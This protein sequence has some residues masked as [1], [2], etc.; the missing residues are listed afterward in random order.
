MS[1]AA[2][3]RSRINAILLLVAGAMA[4]GF[5]LYWH[6]EGRIESLRSRVA[7]QKAYAAELL[8][9]GLVSEAAAV[10]EQAAGFAPASAESLRLRRALADLRMNRLG[11]YEKAL[12]DLVFIKTTDPAQANALEPD[13]R[14]CLDR[15][16]RVYDVQRRLLLEGGANPTVV[17]A[18]QTTAVRFGNEAGITAAELEQRLVLEKIPL[19]GAPREALDRAVQGLLGEK[20]LL[21]AA[22]R[23]Q[24][25][26]RPDFIEQV[27]R[28]EDNLALLRYLEERVMK[29]VDVDEQTIG[30]YLEK[31]RDR[32]QSP[33]RVVYSVLDFPDETSAREYAAGRPASAPRTIGDHL[34]GTRQELPAALQGIRWEADPPKGPLGPVELNGRWV[35]Y[36]IH[37]I[38]A[39]TSVA[40]ELA[41]QQARLELLERRKGDRLSQA[42]AEL[43]R[44]EDVRVIDETIT[45]IFLPAS[46]TA[47]L[48]PNPGK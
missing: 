43:A 33:L 18:T 22:K 19:R 36:M 26:R 12:A 11:D 16:G 39:G 29:D 21:R 32:F 3:L 35:I 37:D 45:R 41:R 34:S 8:A 25:D 47:E 9:H 27:K 31:N 42:I 46:P 2:G 4:V 14:Q 38:V 1:G 40:P 20:L 10:M 6:G 15:L 48:S 28:F 17:A 23:A 30:L 13:I 5:F 24:I 7:Q 44:Q